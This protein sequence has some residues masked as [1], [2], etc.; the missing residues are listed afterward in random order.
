MY[1]IQAALDAAG[2]TERIRE[3]CIVLLHDWLFLFTPGASFIKE[4]WDQYIKEIH[5]KF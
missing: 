2:N 3:P 4:N 5:Q 1:G